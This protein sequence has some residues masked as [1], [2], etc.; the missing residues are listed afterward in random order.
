MEPG[1]SARVQVLSRQGAQGAPSRSLFTNTCGWSSARVGLSQGLR[2]VGRGKPQ[3]RSQG[4]GKSWLKTPSQPPWPN[5]TMF[6]TKTSHPS[7]PPA[8]K[9]F[10]K[11]KPNPCA[12]GNPAFR[13]TP[14]PGSTPGGSQAPSEP[15]KAAPRGEPRPWKADF[16]T[17]PAQRPTAVPEAAGAQGVL[18]TGQVGG[19]R[20]P[21]G[22]DLG[23]H[24]R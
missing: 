11:H 12:L 6:P 4:R 19:S 24:R 1:N 17:F 18:V 3:A 2:M 8:G 13:T 7:H 22:S 15:R 20:T 23:R 5:T 9:A 16:A 14:Y 10:M 21:E